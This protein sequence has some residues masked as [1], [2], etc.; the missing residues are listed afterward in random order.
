[1]A[2]TVRRTGPKACPLHPSPFSLIHPPLPLTL[3]HFSPINPPADEIKQALAG[4]YSSNI[5]ISS[6]RTGS[7]MSISMISEF[8]SPFYVYRLPKGFVAK[9]LTPA[10]PVSLSSSPYL[11]FLWYTEIKSEFVARPRE[12][13]QIAEILSS[14]CCATLVTSSLSLP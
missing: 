1:M 4:L 6:N 9:H 7:S 2:R 10:M 11:V 8:S 13:T 3:A 14:T 5:D 12:Q